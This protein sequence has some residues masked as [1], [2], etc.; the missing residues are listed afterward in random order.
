MHKRHLNMS[1][2]LK[3]L[4]AMDDDTKTA[5]LC[6]MP[7]EMALNLQ[8]NGK[9]FLSI[10]DLVIACDSVNLQ[11]QPTDWMKMIFDPTLAA[12]PRT[13]DKTEI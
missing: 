5:L 8:L 9:E 13:T 7:N 4:T 1:V 12:D 11:E 10:E 6:E 2:K 3:I